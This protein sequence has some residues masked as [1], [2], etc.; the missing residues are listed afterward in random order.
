MLPRVNEIKRRECSEKKKKNRWNEKKHTLNGVCWASAIRR[1]SENF[2]IVIMWTSNWI[3][4]VDMN[5]ASP[6][7]HWRK[8][9]T[10]KCNCKQF[11]SVSNLILSHLQHS[12]YQF[13]R[14]QNLPFSP[15][16]R[17]LRVWNGTQTSQTMKTKKRCIYL[18][19]PKW[20]SNIHINRIPCKSIE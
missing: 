11:G 17:T 2:V 16:R 19:D 8:R 15:H 4:A 5:T 20:P 6:R 3:S 12:V 18:F 13:Q 14:R 9:L 7:T 10:L 1:K